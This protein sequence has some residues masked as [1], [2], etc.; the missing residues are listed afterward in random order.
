MRT[1]KIIGLVLVI[2]GV[3]LLFLLRESLIRMFIFLLELFG[4]LLGIIL[5]VVGLSIILGARY[6]TI[7][8][9]D[10]RV[11]PEND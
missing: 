6:A 5:I 10:Y 1:V 9:R 8:F 3:G 11:V 7:K 2:L 4:I